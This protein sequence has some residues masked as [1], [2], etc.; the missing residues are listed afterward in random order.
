MAP[1]AYVSATFKDLQPHRRI[2]QIVLRRFGYED[3][4]MEYYV[5]EDERPL[6]KC[7]RDVAECDL[8]IGIF[9]WRYGFVPE[10]DNP[11]KLSITE[12]EYRK[13]VELGKPRL[14]FVV[15]E[16]AD[17][18]A[19]FMDLD[20]TRAAQLHESAK[21][22]RLSGTFSTPDSL[23][24]LLS[25]A[26]ETRGGRPLTAAGIDV[27]AYARFLK[28]RYNILD[29]DALT[30]PTRDELLQLRLQSVFVEQNA[31]EDSP[32]LDLPKD[33]WEL[34]V[35]R[36]AIHRED[37]PQGLTEEAVQQ[38]RATYASKPSRPVLQILSALE[39]RCTI[40][41]GDPGS[42]KSTL[43]RFVTLSLLDDPQALAPAL[44]GRLPFLIDLKAYTALRRDGRCETFFDYFDVLA[45]QEDCPVSSKALTAY[46]KNGQPAVV[47]FDGI[48]E[49]F[50]PEEQETVTRQI[51]AFADS[52]PAARVIVTS[53]IIGYRRTILTHAGFR[54]FTLQDFDEEQV[55]SFVRQWYSLTLGNRPDEAQSRVE[56]IRRAFQSSR[57]IRQL[58][59]NPMLLTIMAII[60]KHQELPRERWKLYAH[61]TSVLVQHWDVKR[62]LRN[63][64]LE[65][66][67]DEEDKKDLLRRLAFVMQAGKGGLAGNYIHAVELQAEFEA[68]LSERFGL[69]KERAVVI[70]REMIAQ[71]RER[72]FI[73][74][75][76]G[77]GVY[78]FVHRAFLEYFCAEAIKHKFEKTTELP[79]EKLKTDVFG[80]HWDE[81]VW[82]EV[83][84]LI[85]GMIGEQFA[86]EL[87]ECL[88]GLGYR[89][90][91][92]AN[93]V[94]AIECLSEVRRL[95]QIE[96]HA[97]ELLRTL[98]EWVDESFAKSPAPSQLNQ[99]VDAAG[100]LG[101][102]WPNREW[103]I[104]YFLQR[105]PQHDWYHGIHSYRVGEFL[106]QLLSD[107]HTIRE[108]LLAESSRVTSVRMAVLYALAMAWPNDPHVLA[109]LQESVDPDD[110]SDVPTLAVYAT[111]EYLG[112]RAEAA[113]WLFTLANTRL[114]YSLIT[115]AVR[116]FPDDP[117]TFEVAMKL[118]AEG[119]VKAIRFLERHVGDAAVRDLL[120]DLSERLSPSTQAGK[121][122][123]E[124]IERHGL[125]RATPRKQP[126]RRKPKA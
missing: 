71:F 82:H 120:I 8:Y 31:R 73:L 114:R 116:W 42:G 115:A 52:Y 35:S 24:A 21:K 70:A 122:V 30:D 88:R 113:N 85:C 43:L 46:F 33:A 47:L 26:L 40:L 38:L 104:D 86:G 56:R 6:D 69:E 98:C 58:S 10:T 1:R 9:A 84:R 100:A 45:K 68:Y 90:T 48:D 12:R 109:Y 61:A 11:G 91:G 62:H 55:I 51:A 18:P 64:Q 4:A 27:T 94:L 118:A 41:L 112:H 103:T 37:L 107:S 106:G 126:R 89:E 60:G 34:L 121:A 16:D 81:K 23:A 25:A 54:H 83:L 80:R 5:P 79:L 57:S 110:E 77:A 102:R 92:G 95:E 101:T 117:R 66:L 78:G 20:R 72:N 123:A 39:N 13:A 105:L 44:S 59:G 125:K 15:D 7:L 99:A 14:L 28:R 3:V 75:F 124:I 63:K 65:E 32:L 29:L 36:E 76:Y 87:I 49:I 2:V 67:M 17:W 97:T 93:I 108:R 22:D 96:H 53:R 119:D 111:A 74:S 50:D 19:K